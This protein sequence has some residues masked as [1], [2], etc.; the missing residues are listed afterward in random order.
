VKVREGLVVD[1]QRLEEICRRHGIVELA[2]FGSAVRDDFGPDSDVDL[3]YTFASGARVGWRE[4]H[5]LD[6]ELSELLGRSV[7]LVPRRWLT[8]ALADHVLAEAK[9]LYAA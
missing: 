2:L 4:I 5:E 9:T 1:E 6:R 8:P 7:D 3:L